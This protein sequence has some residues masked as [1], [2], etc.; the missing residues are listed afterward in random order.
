MFIYGKGWLTVVGLFFLQLSGCGLQLQLKPIDGEIVTGPAMTLDPDEYWDRISET[1]VS[2]PVLPDGVTPVRHWFDNGMPPKGFSYVYGGKTAYALQKGTASPY[3]EIFAAYLDDKDYSGVS[4]ALGEGAGIDL[5]KLRSASAAG[6][7]F[8]CRGKNGGEAVYV[9]LLDDDTDGKK[10]QTKVAL[11]DFVSIDTVWQYCMLPLKRFGAKGKYW[12]EQRKSEVLADVDWSAVNEFRLSVNRGENSGAGGKPV[13][14][15]V[16]D[17]AVI[18]EIP[19][20]VDPDEY[21][22]AF[23]SDAP[24]LTL[25]DF[26]TASDT[27]WTTGTGPASTV[28]IALVEATGSNCGARSLAVTYR[29]NDWCDVMSDYRSGALPQE[30]RNWTGYWGIRLT[31][32]SAKAYQTLNLQ[33]SDA[34]N[35]LYIA[36]CGVPQGCNDIIVPFREFEKFPYYQPPDARHDGRFDLDGVIMLDIKP[37]GEGTDGTFLIDNIVLTNDRTV[38]RKKTADTSNVTIHA[39]FTRVITPEVNSGIFGINAQ[40]WDGD[41][42]SVKSAEYVK[43]VGHR[44][45]RFPGGLSADEYH[46]KEMLD[47]KDHNVDIDEFLDFC[48]KTG[49]EPMLTVNFGTG[50]V[51]EAAA[52]VHYVNVEKR[53][54]VRYWEVGNELYGSWHKN[55]CSAE[56]YG[57]RAAEFIRA[58]KKVDPSI[59]ITVVWELESPW[60]RTVFEYVKDIADGVNVHNYPQESGEENDQALL[61]SPQALEGIVARVRRQLADY[62]AAG[63]PYQIWL[64]EWNSVDFNPGPQSLGIVN[65]LFAADYLGMLARVNVEQASYWN[66]HN[67]MFTEGGDYGY[68]SRS[69]V[70][71]GA[72]I[73]RPSYWAFRLASMSL[74]GTLVDCS[75][76]DINV[77]AYM[78]R[79]PDGNASL[80]LINKYPRTSVKVLSGV[81]DFG[82]TVTTMQL[83]GKSGPGGYSTTTIETTRRSTII[84]PPWS[85]TVLQNR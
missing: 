66:I 78:N 55:H 35:E 60:N 83:T 53:R 69:D 82:G 5:R 15:Y 17:V 65:A 22:A 24:D 40:H 6:I 47:A 79:L 84:L 61:A 28:G 8:W 7:G 63:R 67:S 68:L 38:V 51:D 11:R 14:I 50:T 44:V 12:D 37:A 45:I 27:G 52:W 36:S 70:P 80:L 74:R 59:L 29:L 81:P 71:E 42:L 21:W 20:Y 1:V 39:D 16:A 13:S 32:C 48:R 75:T 4:I 58:M 62:G 19:G 64:T 72:N 30:Y 34:G 85:I 25:H 43:A 49:C 2:P 46:W 33:I 41:L 9:G 18:D 31:V 56:V 73:P 77:S 23:S 3:R 26:E 57:R 10:V 54:K 76:D